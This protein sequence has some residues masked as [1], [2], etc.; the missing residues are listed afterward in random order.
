MKVFKLN[1]TEDSISDVEELGYQWS[2][3]YQQD[4]EI[5]VLVNNIEGSLI[6]P[7]CITSITE[8]WWKKLTTRQ[9]QSSIKMNTIQS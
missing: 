8:L 7:S 1:L 2:Y 6:D 9:D 3:S 4:D 5:E